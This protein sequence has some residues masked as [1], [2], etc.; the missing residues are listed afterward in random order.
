M[1]RSPMK[2]RHR[3]TGPSPDVV[4]IVWER[5]FGGCAWCGIGVY[6]E[7]GFHWSVGH[8][9]PRRKGGDRRPETNQP[10]NLV[11]LHGSGTTSC[12]GYVEGHPDES[13]A[14]GHTLPAEAY[15]ALEPIEHA[16][17]G[18]VLLDDEGGWAPCER[19]VA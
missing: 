17:H 12:H 5:D 16:V 9:R 2:T 18:F 13:E 3:N 10:A 14:K 19:S 7:R 8:R 1:K 6:G 4:E 11:L 15:P